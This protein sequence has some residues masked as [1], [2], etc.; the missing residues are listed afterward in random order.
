ML[1]PSAF[2]A[3]FARAIERVISLLNAA[4]K[5]SFETAK[6]AT[7][8]G[9]LR[10]WKIEAVPELHRNRTT[11]RIQ[12]KHRIGALD[13]GTRDR[14]LRN[15]IPI[16]RVPKRMIEPYTAGINRQPLR[17]A[18]QRRSF[19]TAVKHIGLKRIVLSVRK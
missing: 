17:I 12:P 15:E 10:T 18:G 16:H 5:T 6:R 13:R 9:Q 11:Q 19:E 4:L 3:R 1:A 14:V 2:T 8:P 7:A